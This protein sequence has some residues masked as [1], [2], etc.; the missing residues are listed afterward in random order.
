M[1][2]P[3]DGHENNEEN[4]LGEEGYAE[5]DPDDDNGSLQ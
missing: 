4:M 2:I 5:V 3:G 1:D